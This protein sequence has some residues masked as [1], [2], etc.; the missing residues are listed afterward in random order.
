MTTFIAIVLAVLTF[1]FIVYPLLRPGRHSTGSARSERW[2]ELHSR[3]DTTYSMLKELEFDFQSGILTEE[4]YR[5][6]EAKYKRK[7]VS[8]LKSIDSLEKSAGLEAEIEKQVLELR[9]GEGR[10]C[11]Q[12]GERHQADDRFCSQCGANLKQGEPSD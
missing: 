2:Q 3:R 10:F 5:E 9:R 6:L 11:P 4:D 8:I 1:A 7:G 12:C